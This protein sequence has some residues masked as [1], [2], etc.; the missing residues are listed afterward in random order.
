MATN[1]FV[2]GALYAVIV[3]EPRIAPIAVAPVGENR[4]FDRREAFAR[5]DPRA[6][7]GAG[8]AGSRE[9]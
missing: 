5:A 4:R 6:R 3:V 8:G 2:E 1:I 9:G 7:I